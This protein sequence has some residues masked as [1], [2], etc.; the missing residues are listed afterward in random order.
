MTE[1]K[2]TENGEKPDI[3]E[4]IKSLTEDDF[5][6]LG[7]QQVAYIKPVHVKSDIIMYSVHAANGTPLSVMES[8]DSAIGAIRK[9]EL[10]PITVH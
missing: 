9:N 10:E 6:D 8:Y 5:R 4:A 7:I 2:S 1:I 3:Q